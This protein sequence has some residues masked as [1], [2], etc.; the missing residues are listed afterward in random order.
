MEKRAN[1][2]LIKAYNLLKGIENQG[3]FKNIE[4]GIFGGIKRPINGGKGLQG[5]FKKEKNY[6]NPFID[7]MI[8][9][10]TSGGK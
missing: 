9:E 3:L 10:L 8:K 1:E 2:V 7:M 4:K 5:V 6:Y